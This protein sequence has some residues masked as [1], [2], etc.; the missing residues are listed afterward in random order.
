MRAPSPSLTFRFLIPPACL[1]LMLLLL[2]STGF[3]QTPQDARTGE[4]F[5]TS[6]G[7]TRAALHQKTDVT[8]DITGMTARVNV[9]QA[10]TNDTAEWQE[11]TYVFPLPEDSAVNAMKMLVGD[12]E[13]IGDIRERAEAKRVYEQARSEGRRAALTEQQRPN[14]FTQKLANLAPGETISIELQYIQALRYEDGRFSLRF[15][16]TLTPRYIPGKLLSALD[17]NGA[18]ASEGSGWAAATD[19]VPDAAEITPHYI[20]AP[21]DSDSNTLSMT[22]RLDAGLALTRVGSPTHDMAVFDRGGGPGRISMSLRAGRTRMDR[23]FELEWAPETGAAPQAAVFIDPRDEGTFMQIMLLPPRIEEPVTPLGREV[24]IVLDSSGS[25]GGESMVQAKQ[26][27]ELALTGMRACDWFNIIDFDSSFQPLFP[28]SQP[29]TPDT[30]ARARLFVQA[31]QA[32]GGTEMFGALRFALTEPPAVAD[33]QDLLQ[34]IVFITDGAVGNEDALFALIDATLD[35]ARLFTVGIGSAPNSYFMRKAAE[36]GR[37]TYTYINDTRRVAESMSALMRKLENAVMA[38]LSVEWPAG[39]DAEYYPASIPD[40]YLGEPLFVTARL[41]GNISA[42]QNILVSGTIAGQPWQRQLTVDMANASGGTA[43]QPVSASSLASYWAR[44]KIDGLLNTAFTGSG[45]DAAFK[46]RLRQQ[47][48]DVALP[49]Q[50]LSPYTSFVAVE[51]RISRP[52]QRALAST[53][54]GNTPP[55]GQ[56]F[57]AQMAAQ[58]VQYPA[59]ATAA[60]AWLLGGSLALLCAALSL[61]SL[62]REKEFAHA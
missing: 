48:L 58:Q 54:I 26:S 30:I 43:G 7:R 21:A 29:V 33:G 15:P 17:A 23:D 37:G 11:G 50:L 57:A 5:L 34:Q 28:A 19:A 35:D 6:G 55:N 45:N 62:R 16:M 20:A 51:N 9:R 10:F 44:Q 41:D 27:V 52:A 31:L 56:L 25:M 32:D 18:Y 53:A 38:D 13:I 60:G 46:E 14:L 39:V 12:R 4:F 61:L 36:T 49:Y 8:M 22:V 24:I 42:R 47:V 3:A 2:C 59:T 1:W 40:L